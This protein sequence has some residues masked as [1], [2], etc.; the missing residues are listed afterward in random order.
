MRIYLKRYLSVESES[1][2]S[3]LCL[4][5]GLLFLTLAL[6]HFNWVIGNAWGFDAALPTKENGERVLNPKKLDSAIVG[7]GLTL[8]AS[9]YFIKSSVFPIA[10]PAFFLAYGGWTISLI[11]L[12]RAVGDFRY[13][14][15]FKRI[16]GTRFAK[17]DTRYYSPLCL[18]LCMLGIILELNP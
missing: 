5:Q 1:M 8:F 18:C 12:L 15:F 9:F 16:K 3:V 13:V 6:I 7:F 14:G 10:L 11:F 2:F 17:M 4:L